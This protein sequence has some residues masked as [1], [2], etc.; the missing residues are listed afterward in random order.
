MEECDCL[1]SLATVCSYLQS[2]AINI[3]SNSVFPLTQVYFKVCSKYVYE[4]FDRL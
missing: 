1:R 2:E 3:S 4:F